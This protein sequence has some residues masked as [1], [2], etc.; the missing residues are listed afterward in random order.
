MHP[1]NAEFFDFY[2]KS[3]AWHRY[4]YLAGD[5]GAR[6]D[7]VS[8]RDDVFFA[9]PINLPSAAEQ[10]KISILL[11]LIEKK[12]KA[13]FA[14]V[15]N[16]KKYKRGVSRAIFTQE[17]RLLPEADDWCQTEVGNIGEIIMGQSPDSDSYNTDGV[18]VPLVQGNADMCNG[19]T[20]PKR[21][22]NKPTKICETGSIIL[23][24]RAPV[25]AV[26]R[27]DRQICIGRGVCAINTD[28]NDYLYHFLATNESYWKHI[29]QGGTFTAISGDDIASM[30]VLYPPI[31]EREKIAHFL[32]LIDAEVHVAETTEMALLTLKNSLL[33]NL[34]I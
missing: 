1:I 21:F 8:I 19:I 26:G 23:S 9:M 12:I 24:V 11:T 27:A 5:S 18:G 2:F 10:N 6:H 16:L 3:S 20:S 32:N 7:R 14:L 4:I 31:E 17:I 34:F 25:G 30:P 15:E 13:Q 22:T 29:E 28:N 33:K